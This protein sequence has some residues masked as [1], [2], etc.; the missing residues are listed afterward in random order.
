MDIVQNITSTVD[1]DSGLMATNWKVRTARTVGEVEAV[2]SVWQ[3]LHS[4]PNADID[5]YLSINAVR[6]KVVRPHI[7]LFSKSSESTALIVGRIEMLGSSDFLHRLALKNSM[8]RKLR[9]IH[10]GFLGDVDDNLSHAVM[11]EILCILRRR[12]VG[13]VQLDHLDVKS[14]MYRLATRVP[15]VLS[16]DRYIRSVEHWSGYIGSS[17]KEYC[18]S[19]SKNTRRNLRRYTSLFSN[20]FDE[21][22]SIRILNRPSDLEQIMRDT[23]AI[24][25]KTYQYALPGGF[26]CDNER[27][28]IVTLALERGWMRSFILYVDGIP[29]A[30]WNGMAYGDTFYA[31]TTG[32]DPKFARYHI[33][34][35]LLAR[36][37]ENLC[38]D[39]SIN[40]IDFGLGAAQYK[41]DYCDELRYEAP[42][43]V[44]G[45]SLT[46][47]CSNMAKTAS[48]LAYKGAR[49]VLVSTNT[50]QKVRRA[51]RARLAV[52][53]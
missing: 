14:E 9:I 18:D 26:K 52:G 32:F 38:Q 40:R 12:E 31:W 16:K 46:A 2:R 30:F 10:G 19:R 1:R 13:I 21:R 3:R 6:K 4:H 37:F 11:D 47:V 8:L 49:R 35:F 27:R 39:E 51:W 29:S 36:L 34:T 24:A 48:S 22:W 25:S 45:P 5:F 41:R 7:M 28:T 15:G 17:Y 20:A 23:E 42:V 53:R 43:C 33:G 44:Y 50:L